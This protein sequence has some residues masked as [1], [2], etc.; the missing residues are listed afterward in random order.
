[1]IFRLWNI[2]S[3]H[4]AGSLMRVSREQSK[5]KLDLVGVQEVR[6]EGGGTKPA[7][8]YTFFYGKG[9]RIMNYVQYFFFALAKVRERLAVNTQ[10]SHRFQMERFNLK[11]L[12]FNSQTFEKV[13]RLDG[14]SLFKWP[15][16]AGG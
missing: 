6:W 13:V 16:L 14:R 5:Y 8:E 15:L 3:L 7:G 12:T 2:S 4:R 10:R 1:M 11:K 9:M